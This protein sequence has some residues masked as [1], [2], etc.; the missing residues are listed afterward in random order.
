M[1]EYD[2]SSEEIGNYI[3]EF[4]FNNQVKIIFSDIENIR[5]RLGAPK[6]KDITS[7]KASAINID[8]LTSSH[9]KSIRDAIHI[10][11]SKN[12]IQ[13]CKYLFNGH[14]PQPNQILK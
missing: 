9:K 7:S 13:K 2:L 12:H 10:E 11:N 3:E 5:K 4:I 1:F 6:K 8:N 14:L